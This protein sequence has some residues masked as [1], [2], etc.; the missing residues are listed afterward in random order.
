MHDDQSK[1][2]SYRPRAPCLFTTV[3][4]KAP[5]GFSTKRGGRDAMGAI[6]TKRQQTVPAA[7]SMRGSYVAYTTSLPPR[8]EI[9]NDRQGMHW[10]TDPTPRCRHYHSNT[11]IPSQHPV[12]GRPRPQNVVKKTTIWTVLQTVPS[13]LH[14]RRS[15]RL[16]HP[17][18]KSNTQGATTA[19][20]ADACQW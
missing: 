17:R 20:A 4:Y 10:H 14:A 12:Y 5:S 13:H 8:A 18:R 1:V 2:T 16:L 7:Q 11:L 6:S 3:I 9:S 15:L 19:P